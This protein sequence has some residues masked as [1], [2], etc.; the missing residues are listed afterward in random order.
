MSKVKENDTVKVHYTGK[1]SNGQVFDSS[2]ER[3]PLEITLGKGMLIPGFEK[4]IIAMEVNEKKT[5]NIPVEEAYGEVNKEL[6]YD[7]KKEQ[8]PP[9]MTPEVGMG[10][11]SK[12]ENGREIQFRVA[13]VK[14]D[15]IVVDANHPLAGH[16][17]IFDLEL[18][19][20]K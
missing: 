6:F 5:I 12:D 9:D 10:L 7:V 18:V 19:E 4:G 3:E 20:I 17:L 11:A 14:E 8:L 15:H 2:L 13:E 1:L 16:E